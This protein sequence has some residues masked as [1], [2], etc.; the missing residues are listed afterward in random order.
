MRGNTFAGVIRWQR[1][2]GLYGSLIS[3]SSDGFELPQVY[4]A[5]KTP[6]PSL[7]SPTLCA[8]LFAVD[9][10]ALVGSVTGYTPSPVVQINGVPV[11]DALAEEA[12]HQTFHDPDARYNVLMVRQAA[13]SSGSWVNPWFY[14]G[15]NMTFTFA[16]GTSRSVA[17][18]AYVSSAFSFSG[19]STGEAF[20]NKFVDNSAASGTSTS[21]SRVVRR[22]VPTG[23]PTPV[24]QHSGSDIPL[25]GFY[26]TGAGFTDVAVLSMNTFNY[27]ED[28]DGVLFQTTVQKFLAAAKAAGKK[29]MIID[30]SSNGGGALFLGYD[31]FK[32][33]CFV[34]LHHL[35]P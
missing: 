16:N 24:I 1:G 11:A 34:L 8:N 3:I 21:T 14:P 13:E 9:R 4:V 6:V 5:G 7:S 31:T 18:L 26:L 19:V 35:V 12:D 27:E 22:T 30:V 17:N 25:G 23:Y 2:N 32:Q 28:S 29:K 15:N 33:V 20:Y 10:R